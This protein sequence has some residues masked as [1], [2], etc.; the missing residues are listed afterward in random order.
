MTVTE[1]SVHVPPTIAA[2]FREVRSVTDELSR[3]L[4]PEDQV[5][6]SMPDV[7]PTKWHRAHTTWFF[8]TFVLTPHAPAY[9]VVHPGYDYLF[10]SYYEQV[11]PRYPRADRGLI[12]RPTVEQVGTYRH[13]VDDSVERL[14]DS[15]DTERKQTVE[16]LVELGLHHEQQ[17]QEL[18][19]MDIKHV[20]SRN[21]L[22][23]SYTSSAPP[24]PTSEPGPTGWVEMEVPGALASIGHDGAGFCFDSE[25]PAHRALVEPFRIAQRLVT[26]GEWL[27][28]MGDGGYERP[29]LWLSE[30]WATVQESGWRAPL[31][32]QPEG[33]GWS[34]FTLHGYHPV[35]PAEPVCHV[36]FFEADA[37]ARWAG[38]RLPSEAEWEVAVSTR[39]AVETP[40]DLGTGSLHPVPDQGAGNSSGGALRQSMGDVWEWTSSPYR[41]YPRYRP[42]A[43]A[44][45]EYNGKFM[46]NQM[47]LRGGSCVTPAGHSRP[48]YRNFFPPPARWVFAGLRLAADA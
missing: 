45:G 9:R 6:Q 47:V 25:Q 15:V 33:D 28:F 42:A 27:A 48:T 1:K 26:V 29:E 8:E 13:A 36:S 34:T 23:P 35:Q 30:G 22:R 16:A 37:F 38:A 32:W 18:L 41:P 5:V 14:L 46:C 20:L 2:A 17:H 19:L 11:G 43:G 24:R 40:N 4:A 44:I 39:A 12:S 10:N 7:S 21:P 3:P 31:Y